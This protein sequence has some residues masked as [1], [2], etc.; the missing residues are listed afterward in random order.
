MDIWDFELSQEDMAEIAQM[1]TGHSEVVDHFSP[2]TAKWL[3]GFKIH[4]QAA[5]SKSGS[6]FQWKLM[7]LTTVSLGVIVPP[8]AIEE[9]TAP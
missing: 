1:D 3:N 8:L 4:A 5:A 9:V 6:I 2:Q 7:E